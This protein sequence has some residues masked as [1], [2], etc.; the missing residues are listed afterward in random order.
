MPRGCFHR[1]SEYLSIAGNLG[2]GLQR[3]KSAMYKGR[4]SV[5]AEPRLDP[6]GRRTG[7]GEGQG[8]STE[9]V[10]Q[11]GLEGKDQQQ[12]QTL[13]EW[14]LIRAPGGRAGG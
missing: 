14:T 3:R 8:A 5:T 9:G 1:S 2:C 7:S 4:E 10:P 11:P 13:K 6:W 12:R